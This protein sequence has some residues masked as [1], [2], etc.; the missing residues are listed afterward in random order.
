M[1]ITRR[2]LLTAMVTVALV[3]LVA[4]GETPQSGQAAGVLRANAQNEIVL[5]EPAIV[6]NTLLPAGTYKLH[7]RAS[8]TTHQV[9]FMREETLRTV[10]PETSS[11]EVYDE[12]ARV[13]SDTKLRSNAAEV[14]TLHYY[15]E[16]DGTMHIVSADIKGESHSHIF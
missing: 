16:E 6:A 5:D 8:G 11:V 4:L 3:A 10:F 2:I 7:S 15:V 14:T 1:I 9:Y 12:A 13:K